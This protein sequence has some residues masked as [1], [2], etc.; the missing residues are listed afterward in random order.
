MRDLK[1]VCADCG[2]YCREEREDRDD[3]AGIHTCYTVCAVCGC[4]ELKWIPKKKYGVI[5][6]D[7]PWRFD[8]LN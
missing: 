1:M 4:S 5:V 7:P 8:V 2:V 3:E 6:V